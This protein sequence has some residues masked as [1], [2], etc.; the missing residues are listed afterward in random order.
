M[1]SRSNSCNKAEKQ[2][3]EATTVINYSSLETGCAL[4]LQRLS[5]KSIEKLFLKDKAQKPNF[6]GNRY[7]QKSQQ[8]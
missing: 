8:T 5:S 7:I 3:F 1:K 6:F 2:K 4:C